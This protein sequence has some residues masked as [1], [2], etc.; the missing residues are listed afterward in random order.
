MQRRNIWG[1]LIIM[2]LLIGCNS[3]NETESSAPLA[4]IQEPT[5]TTVAVAPTQEDVATT[6]PTV[7][8]TVEINEPT[9]TTEPTKVATEPAPSPQPEE[10]AA[11]ATDESVTEPEVLPIFDTHIHYSDDAWLEYTPEEIIEKLERAEVPRALFSSSPD[12]G[13]RML[14]ELDP[15]RIVPSL[16]PYHGQV[17]SSNWFEDVTIL[18]YFR[19]RLET[20]VYEGI[21]EFHIHLNEDADSPIIQ[22]TVALAIEQD[23]ILQIHTKAPA[24]DTIFGYA[25]EAKILWGH[26]G[27][28][29]P[30]EV[31][32]AMLDKYENLWIDT[33]LRQGQIAPNGVLDPTWEAL[34]LKHPDRVTIGSDTWIP[35]RWGVYQE[36]IEYDRV[37]LDQLPPDIARQIAY[38]NAV[39]LFGAG[40]HEHLE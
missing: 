38:G 20:P 25:P 6:A 12:E 26:A 24:I 34:F 33:S 4:D 40:P 37:W 11:T 32:M 7:T 5:P 28:S 1:V 8:A 13:T 14:Y 15:D 2:T 10:L 29:E 35:S 39:R 16:R 9:S 27:L 21:G 17:T 30:P 36:I 19:D 22:E 3:A 23:L 31:V 18:S